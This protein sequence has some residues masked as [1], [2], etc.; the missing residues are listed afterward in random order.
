MNILD[1]QVDWSEEYDNDPT[2][3]VVVDKAPDLNKL[4]HVAVP[5]DGGTMYVALQDGVCHF[6]CST[7]DKSGYGGR[8]FD[9]TMADGRVKQVIG[10]W[11]SR[12]GVVNGLG[13]MGWPGVVE[14]Y[15]KETEGDYPNM[16]Y[17][18]M[19]LSVKLLEPELPA[20]IELVPVGSKEIRYTPQW[21]GR[22]N[23]PDSVKGQNYVAGKDWYKTRQRL[24]LK[25]RYDDNYRFIEWET[26]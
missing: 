7:G 5:L 14:V 12:A 16:W 11:S 20:G 26:T 18:G 1:V 15:H 9:L 10:P 17:H 8:K 13:L 2:L 6:L 24:G 3:R 23:K 21:N 25:R 4:P 19:S 22:N